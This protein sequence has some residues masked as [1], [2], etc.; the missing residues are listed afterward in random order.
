MT[1]ALEGFAV[2]VEHALGATVMDLAADREVAFRHDEWCQALVIV[3]CGSLQLHCCSGRTATFGAGSI[4]YFEGLPLRAISAR[5]GPA[6]LL[7]LRP[8]PGS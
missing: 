5:G 2:S 1:G 7:M 6:L 3:Q 4:L 8:P